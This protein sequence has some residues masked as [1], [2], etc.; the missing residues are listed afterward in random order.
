MSVV[1]SSRAPKK[2]NHYDEVRRNTAEMRTFLGLSM[3]L[4]LKRASNS[5]EGNNNSCAHVDLS[6]SCN[7]EKSMKILKILSDNYFV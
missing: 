2:V 7:N 4:Q 5:S 1:L 3:T 6:S